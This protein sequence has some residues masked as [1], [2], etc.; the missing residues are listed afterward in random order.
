MSKR[1]LPLGSL[2]IPIAMFWSIRSFEKGKAANASIS[3]NLKSILG[4]V[5]FLFLF[6]FISFSKIKQPQERYI[7]NSLSQQ[8]EYYLTKIMVKLQEC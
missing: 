1:F 4:K 6:Y 8:T 7:W 5:N 2:A 3:A